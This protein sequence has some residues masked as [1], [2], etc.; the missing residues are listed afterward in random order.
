MCR[1]EKRIISYMKLWEGWSMT[2]SIAIRTLGTAGEKYKK[3]LK[4]SL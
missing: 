3:L 2:Y 1:E 4:S